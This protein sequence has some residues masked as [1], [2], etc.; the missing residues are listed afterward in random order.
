MKTTKTTIQVT[1]FENG[2]IILYEDIH[3]CIVKTHDSIFTYSK[4][5]MEEVYDY[6]K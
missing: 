4:E 3:K 6:K 2:D 1:K 5:E